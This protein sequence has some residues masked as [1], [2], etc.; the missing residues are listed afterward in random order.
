MSHGVQVPIR[1]QSADLP[2]LWGANCEKPLGV[3]H[4]TLEALDMGERTLGF[5]LSWPESDTLVEQEQDLLD[6][7]AKRHSRALQKTGTVPIL[8]NTPDTEQG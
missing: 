4:R 8:R 3:H 5:R 2:H 6:A 1:P 7:V